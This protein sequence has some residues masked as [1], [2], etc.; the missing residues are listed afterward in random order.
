MKLSTLLAGVFF[1]AGLA[2]ASTNLAPES[3]ITLDADAGSCSYRFENGDW[4]LLKNECRQGYH[5]AS[6]IEEEKPAQFATV[7]G[8]CESL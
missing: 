2:Q 1:F 8:S 7:E 4:K 5:P 3:K 6:P